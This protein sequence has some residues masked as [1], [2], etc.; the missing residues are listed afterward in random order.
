MGSDTGMGIK[1]KI[2]AASALLLAAIG[3]VGVTMFHSGAPEADPEA[4]ITL[5]HDKGN[6]PGFQRHFE[7][8]GQKAKQAAG[9]GFEPVAYHNTDLF[10]HQMNASLPTRDAPELFT[11]W[12]TYRVKRLVEKDLVADLTH[13]WDKHGDDYPRAIRE[14]YTLNGRVYGFPYSVEYWPVWYNKRLFERLNIKRPETWNEFI[15]ACQVLKANGIPPILSSLQLK[16]YTFVW[17][18]ELVIGEDP[19]FY[20]QLC[21]G[22][23]SYSDPRLRKALLLWRDMIDQGYFS[24]PSTHMFTNAGHL[25]NNEKFGMVLCGSWYYSTVLLDQGVDR[26]TIG[27]FILPSHNPTAGKNIVM[28]SG[29]ILTAKNAAEKATAEK[30]VDWWMG[31]EGNTHFSKVFQSYSANK[32]AG[33]SHL[34]PAKQELLAA[35]RGENYRILNRYWE[36]TPSPIVDKAVNLFAR[37][38]LNPEEMDA[39]IEELTLTADTYWAEHADIIGR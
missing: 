21:R 36:A 13:I 22:T 27:V 19:D 1:T 12:S 32:R 7:I 5:A 25:W 14:A 9:V 3:L 37:F 16:W 35:I 33:T 24:D 4:K 31:P 11:W 8:Q 6:L 39:V 10:V 23:A 28:E 29:P 20:R 26:E 15:R 18:E 34:H 38:I 17:F 30:I 2:T